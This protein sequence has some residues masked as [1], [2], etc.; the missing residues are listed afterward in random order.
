M[1]DEGMAPGAECTRQVLVQQPCVD[2]KLL[3]A[4]GSVLASLIERYEVCVDQRR[5][6]NDC[7][8]GEQQVCLRLIIKSSDR[9]HV[10]QHV[11]P[12]NRQP[13]HRFR[14]IGDR[15]DSDFTMLLRLESFDTERML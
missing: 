11:A 2:G 13:E 1:G 3:Q 12:A 5:D 6:R 10:M 15:V 14:D 7:S 4:L 9:L 8:L